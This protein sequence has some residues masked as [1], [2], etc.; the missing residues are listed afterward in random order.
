MKKI[1][2]SFLFIGIWVLVP[3]A[4]AADAITTGT[5]NL[6]KGPGVHYAKR[7][8]VPSGSRLNVRTCRGSWCQINSRRGTGWVS[9]RFLAFNQGAVAS[10]YYRRSSPVV[11]VTFA[12]NSRPRPYY[13]RTHRRGYHYRTYHHRRHYGTM[14]HHKY[15][16]RRFDR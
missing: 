9:A 4:H 6:R 11:V 3:A 14:R 7:G 10:S 2:F 8:V 5:V 1:L 15:Y 12:I 13:Y 16:H